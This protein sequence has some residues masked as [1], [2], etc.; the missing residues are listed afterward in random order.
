[1][2]AWPVQVQHSRSAWKRPG[3][4]Q[5]LRNA[6]SLLLWPSALQ[7]VQTRGTCSWLSLPRHLH[8]TMVEQRV[9][10]GAVAGVV[11]KAKA[12]ARAEVVARAA[13]TVARVLASLAVQLRPQTVDLS[14]SATITRRSIALRPDALSSTA[15]ANVSAAIPCSVALA[16]RLGQPQRLRAGA[17]GCEGGQ[18]RQLL[19]PPAPR[20]L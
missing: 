18:G 1:M 6:I 12:K 17:L 4:A 15:V 20:S 5:S 19:L 13:K 2:T 10:A 3:T 16:M 9:V 8:L 11:A 7:E 14:V